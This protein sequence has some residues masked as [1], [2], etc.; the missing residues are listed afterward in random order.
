MHV[1]FSIENVD[2]YV[3]M[4]YMILAFCGQCDYVTHLTITAVLSFTH[5]RQTDHINLSEICS[6]K[7]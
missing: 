7:F 6:R 4:L 1:F 5:K 3:N 2:I